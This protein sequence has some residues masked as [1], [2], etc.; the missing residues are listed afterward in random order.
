MSFRSHF[1]CL[2]N[3]D[4][5]CILQH[6]NQCSILVCCNCIIATSKVFALDENVGHSALF[7]DFYKS[8]LHRSSIFFVVKLNN[9]PSSTQTLQQLLCSYTIGTVRFAVQ[10]H[11]TPSSIIT[12]ASLFLRLPFLICAPWTGTACMVALQSVAS[13]C[14]IHQNSLCFL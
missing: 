2:Y 12:R 4:C 3:D 14:S 9:F 11:Q 6:R 10:Q 8:C 5:T 13:N 7:R 1:L